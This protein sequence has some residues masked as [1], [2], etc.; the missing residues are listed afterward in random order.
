[1]VLEP[2]KITLTNLPTERVEVTVPNFPNE[3]E[4]G[5]H[6]VMFC[7]VIYIEASDF[8]E[9]PEK[10]YRRLTQTQSVGLRHAGYVIKVRY[11]YSFYIKFI[12]NH[13]FYRKGVSVNV[14]MFFDLPN[15]SVFG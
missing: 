7:K 4:K 3:P 10:G 8:K 9:E 13:G 5:S 15:Y 12:R 6:K 11:R 1:M 14:I 2:L